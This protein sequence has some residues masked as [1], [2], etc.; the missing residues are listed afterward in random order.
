MCDRH[1]TNPDGEKYAPLR[2]SVSWGIIFKALQLSE[3]R[4]LSEV[5]EEIHKETGYNLSTTTLHDWVMDRE[6]L[7]RRMPKRFLGMQEIGKEM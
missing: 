6:K 1:F 7:L 3:S 2:R 5:C 4:I